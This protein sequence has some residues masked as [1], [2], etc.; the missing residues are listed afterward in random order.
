MSKK[1]SSGKSKNNNV[2][3]KKKT[4][5][6]KSA[7][8]KS[9][10]IETTKSSLHGSNEKSQGKKIS[11]NDKKTIIGVIVLIA[12]F[13]VVGIVVSQ[14][15]KP[16]S[17]YAD[18]DYDKYIKLGNYK[19]LEYIYDV[20]E[21]TDQDINEQIAIDV[22]AASKT[23]DRDTVQNGYT[24]TMDYIGSQ[25]GDTIS[26]WTETDASIDIGA[27][28]FEDDMVVPL[29]GFEDAITKAIMGAKVGDKVSVDVVADDQ[30]SVVEAGSSVHFSVMIKSIQEYTTPSIEEYVRES[31]EFKTVD[32]YKA[33]VKS[34][35]EKEAIENEDNLLYEQLWEKVV[36][37]TEVIS[38]PEDLVEKQVK[39]LKADDEEY[40][41]ASGITVEEMLKSYGTTQAKYDAEVKKMAKESVR[42]QLITFA[43]AK[44]EGIDISNEAY[45][46]ALDKYLADAELTREQVEKDTGMTF[47][48]YCEANDLYYTFVSDSV[49]DKLKELGKDVTP[50]DKTTS[51]EEKTED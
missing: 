35:L 10:V 23:E 49:I 30:Q 25:N 33:H 46:K 7:V 1:R 20:S 27:G 3:K 9:D 11:V 31:G 50:K 4:N 38:Y 16:L 18:L 39:L 42:D 44:K 45:Q 29:N 15:S 36:A 22:D 13:I 26:Q 17:D 2:S 8:K 41:K 51:T 24:V 5:S 6:N 19:G 28:Y 14:N 43:I 40:A 21:I 32:E 12:A 47:K 48:K 34:E 37:T